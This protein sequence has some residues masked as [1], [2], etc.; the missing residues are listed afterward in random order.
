MATKGVWQLKEVTIRYCQH[1]GS[2]RYIRYDS[3]VS[4]AVCRA[5]LW[6]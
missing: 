5:V 2:S 1:G 4:G 6:V 3:G